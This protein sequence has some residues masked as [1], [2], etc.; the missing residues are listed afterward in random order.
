M[1]AP[2]LGERLELAVGRVS[3]ESNEMILDS[4]HL[5]ETQGELS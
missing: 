4:S 2:G 5:G 3:A 1:L